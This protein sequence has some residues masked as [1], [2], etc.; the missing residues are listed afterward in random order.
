MPFAG[1]SASAAS[2]AFASAL[3]STWAVQVL[4]E[5]E[6][7]SNVIEAYKTFDQ[8]TPGWVKVELVPGM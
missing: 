5:V 3:A 2:K 7:L 6:P 4:T 8:R 1:I